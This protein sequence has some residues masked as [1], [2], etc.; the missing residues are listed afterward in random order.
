MPEPI[1]MEF[2]MYIM[3]P[4]P[5]STAYFV[6]PSRQFICM[7]IPPFFARQRLG[8]HVPAAKS[9]RNNRSD[10]WCVILCAVRIL[11]KESLWVC[12]CI[13]LPLLG[14]SSVN[15]FSGNG[16][17]LEVSFSMRSMSYK[18]KV[19]NYFFPEVLVNQFISCYIG[20][21]DNCDYEKYQIFHL[22]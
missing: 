17:L 22:L 5:I 20:F 11:S 21:N 7:F 4:E 3:A 19:G 13:P 9:T 10:V 8:K 12:L 2:G 14:N 6:N 15:S 1:F 18:W 16:K